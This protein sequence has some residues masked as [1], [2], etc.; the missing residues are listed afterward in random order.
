VHRAIA[1]G[2]SA[3]EAKDN[4]RFHFVIYRAAHCAELLRIIEH[5][6]L[7]MGPYLSWLI[8]QSGWPARS[9]GARAFRHHKDLVIALRRRDPDKAEAALRADLLTAA[10]V[11]LKQARTLLPP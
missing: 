3:A 2:V 7:Q 6:W 5:L 1:T 11:L 10:E 9:R 8:S 4:E